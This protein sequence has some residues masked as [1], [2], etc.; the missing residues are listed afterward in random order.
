M[1]LRELE[2]ATKTKLKALE[3][4]SRDSAHK[5]QKLEKQIGRLDAMD[6]K[7]EAV[8]ED[9]KSIASQL[10]DSVESQHSISDGL[11]ALQHNSKKQLEDMGSH[12]LTTAE[13]VNELTSAM[14]D[15]KSEFAKLSQ[16]KQDLDTR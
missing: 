15:I 13:N 7:M 14:S 6:K 16:F 4:T 5:L 9:L 2:S 10:E 8:K 12:L 11:I 3:A 1:K